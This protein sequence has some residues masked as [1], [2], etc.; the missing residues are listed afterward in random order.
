MTDYRLRGSAEPAAVVLGCGAWVSRRI[1]WRDQ[2]EHA[3][4][5]LSKGSRVAVVG[6]LWQRSWTAEDGSARSTV[7]VVAEELGPS[8]RWATATTTRTHAQAVASSTDATGRDAKHGVP[9]RR[10]VEGAGRLSRHPKAGPAGRLR[11]PSRAGTDT[12]VAQRRPG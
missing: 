5:S 2:A 3:A 8:L 7:E 11:R 1:V 4:Q 9:L 12:T 6:R 10:A